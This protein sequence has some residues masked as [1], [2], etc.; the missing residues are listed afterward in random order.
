MIVDIFV[1]CYID[2]IYPGTAMNMVKIL[3][4]IGCGVNY[5]QE[6]T[7]CGQPCFNSGYWDGAKEIGEKFIREFLNDRYIVCPSAS[8]VSYVKNYFPEMFHNT[9]LHNEFKQVQKNIIELTDF[10]VNILK[11]TDLGATLNGIATYHDSCSALRAYGLKKEPRA[12]LE[13]V[14]GLELREME[15]TDVCCGFG[16]SFS[17]KMEPISISMA[18]KKVGNALNT[19]AE[20]MI[21]SDMS[22]LMHLDG[23]IK[24]QQKPIK[25]MHIADVLT[26]GW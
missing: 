9:V 21:S 19:Q 20:Y 12:L 22:C 1:P 23:Y 18:E 6:Q 3:E 25:V 13:K 24:K 4:K 26:S 11:I 5:N 17:V 15:D 8:C 2:Q 7:C 10:L 14:K 16:G